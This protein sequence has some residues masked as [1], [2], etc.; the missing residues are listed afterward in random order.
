M[1]HNEHV[2]QDEP[3]AVLRV[4]PTMSLRILRI[5]I[6]KLLKHNARHM[7]L[8]I[9]LRIGQGTLVKLDKEDDARDLDWL[10]IERGSEIVY[11]A[12]E[13]KYE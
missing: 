4:L 5:K 1:K 9:W 7:D 13:H 10:G 3:E 8:T 2:F 11:R 12:Q 6:C